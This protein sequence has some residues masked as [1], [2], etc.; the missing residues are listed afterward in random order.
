VHTDAIL[1]RTLAALE[2]AN[3]PPDTIVVVTSD[4]GEAH[5]EHG[6]LPHERYL[7]DEIVR[8]PLLV[9]APGRMPAGAVVEGGCGPV[10]LTPTLLELAGLSPAEDELDGRSLVELAHGRPG[11]HPIV[12]TADRYDR[13]G[14]LSRA[15]RE[16]TVRDE[17]PIWCYVYDLATADVVAE[18]AFDLVKDPRSLDPRPVGSIEWRDPVFCRLVTATLEE[19]RQRSSLPPADPLCSVS[20]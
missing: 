8:V 16:I 15:V 19:A 6:Y 1:S 17:R 12:S 7:H 11:G 20:R 18:H 13:T 2:A 3:L 14:G 5:G 4:H 10:D 9:R